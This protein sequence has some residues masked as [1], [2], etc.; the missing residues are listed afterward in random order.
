VTVLGAA[1]IALGLFL[2]PLPGPGWLIVFA[3]LAILAIEFHWARQLLEF[4]RRQVQRWTDWMKR[5]S[6]VVRSLVASVGLAF[7]LMVVWASVRYGIGVD[8]WAW[9]R[10]QFS[11]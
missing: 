6:L 2:I 9:A 11:R 4:A 3:G 1:T 7:V 8:L 5:Q 10:E